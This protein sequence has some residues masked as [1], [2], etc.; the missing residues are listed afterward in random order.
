MAE[1]GETECESKP[2]PPLHYCKQEQKLCAR[3]LLGNQLWLAFA[4]GISLTLGFSQRFP[5][6]NRKRIEMSLI[7]PLR[8]NAGVLWVNAVP[9]VL[10]LCGSAGGDGLQHQINDE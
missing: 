3:V 7:V 1:R 10:K 6:L 4:A 8:G 2:V 5:P 9:R